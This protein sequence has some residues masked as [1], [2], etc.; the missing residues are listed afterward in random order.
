MPI[1][2]F[3][4]TGMLLRSA[5]GVNADQAFISDKVHISIRARIALVEMSSA[6]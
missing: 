2:E 1:A 5:F 6:R 3:Q 4:V